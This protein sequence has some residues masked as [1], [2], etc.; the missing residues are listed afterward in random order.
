ML[1]TSHTEG[2]Q[3]APWVGPSKGQWERKEEESREVSVGEQ[4]W[5]VPMPFWEV[6]KG[7]WSPTLWFS[8]PSQTLPAPVWIRLAPPTSQTLLPR[9]QWGITRSCAP[10]GSKWNSTLKASPESPQ[11]RVIHFPYFKNFTMMQKSWASNLRFT[12]FL[13]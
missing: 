13:C 12:L 10:V 7:R 2:A 6:S 3:L 4:H 5:W 9:S 1:Q 11:L 8:H